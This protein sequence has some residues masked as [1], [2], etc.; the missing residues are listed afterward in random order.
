MPVA[1]RG[2]A[3][4]P[5]GNPTT[6]YT[7]TIPSAVVAGDWLELPFTSRD[8]NAV[9]AL[10]TVT[11]NDTGGNTWTVTAL[12][13]DRKALIAR[14]RATSGTASKSITVA[15]CVGSATGVLKCWSGTDT[16]ASPVTNEVVETNLSTDETHAGFTPSNADSMICAAIFNTAN[17]NAVTSLA[18]ATLGATTMTE[19]LS[20]G[21]SDC[22]TAFGHA[23]Q[24]GGPAATGNLTWA[25]TDGATYSATWAL[26]PLASES[27]SGT[28]SLTSGGGITAPAGTQ[29]NAAP[30][31]T[32]GGGVALAVATQRNVA[33]VFAS[34]GGATIGSATN[35][36]ATALLAA[37]GGI[38]APASTQ[39]NSAPTL[40]SGG[41]ISA[42]G[43]S[44]Q[45]SEEH[46][47][48]V[49]LTAG[50]GVSLSIA[51]QRSSVAALISGG[52]VAFAIGTNRALTLV[53]TSGGTVD[54]V[55]ATARQAIAQLEAGGYIT[56]SGGAPQPGTRP[57]EAEPLAEV[58]VWLA[59]GVQQTPQPAATGFGL[60]YIE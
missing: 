40:T 1:L 55:G 53:L 36:T 14:K 10:P 4:V 3:V 24:S 21:G 19:K 28:A 37:G 11:D 60:P 29:R 16:A 54:L 26:K 18:F 30:A 8:H 12:S 9:T 41:G 39:R 13:L 2:A 58:R 34:G 52:G 49:V 33:H 15:G 27:H 44:D 51:T 46:S 5:S 25:Q 56:I 22:A 32:S 57:A 47:G 38:T 6:G 45:G 17:D 23:L 59:P 31:L 43:D 50:G 42:V 20:T 35:R 48:S 7:L